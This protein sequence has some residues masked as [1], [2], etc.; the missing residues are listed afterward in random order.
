MKIKKIKA[1]ETLKKLLKLGFK[2]SLETKGAVDM[3]IVH[4]IESPTYYL[5]SRDKTKICIVNSKTGEISFMLEGT[6]GY[7]LIGDEGFINNTTRLLARADI[8][9]L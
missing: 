9:E 5:V 6:G 7:E 2:N 4:F 1:E 8:L 3:R